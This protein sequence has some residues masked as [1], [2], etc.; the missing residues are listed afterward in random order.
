V[1]WVPNARSG[2]DVKTVNCFMHSL[3]GALSR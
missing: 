1:E 3:D 2:E